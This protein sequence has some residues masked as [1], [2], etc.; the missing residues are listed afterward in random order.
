MNEKYISPLQPVYLLKIVLGVMVL[1]G[2]I[3][4]ANELSLFG[5]SPLVRN[6]LL[7]GLIVISASIVPFVRRVYSKMDELQ[8]ILHQTRA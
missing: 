7:G 2:L 3:V 1:A 4:S 5:V 6:F 8:K